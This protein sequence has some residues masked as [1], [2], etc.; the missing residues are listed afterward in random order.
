M[1]RL[2]DT[3]DIERYRKIYRGDALRLRP[4]LL[5]TS[6]ECFR[7]DSACRERSMIAMLCIDNYL[8]LAKLQKCFRHN[9]VCRQE[10]SVIVMLCICD[11]WFLAMLTTCF[12]HNSVCRQ[13]RSMIVMIAFAI[14]DSLRRERKACGMIW[15][16]IK[17]DPS[18]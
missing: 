6:M 14:V 18:L 8:F 16:A 7:H 17:T 2:V 1:I 13:E 11:R 10:R 15:F 5:A 3:K 9:S 4:L 12:R